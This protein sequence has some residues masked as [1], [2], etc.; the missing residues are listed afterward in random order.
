M[1]P[2]EFCREKGFSSTILLTYNF[3]PIFF[4]RVA[5]KE[6]WAGETGDILVVADRN[7]IAQS[8]PRWDGQLRELG[9]RY[10]LVAAR[11]PGTFHPKLILRVG[12]E[13]AAVWL[14]SGNVTS[15]GWGV[16]R[17]L[18][19]GWTVGPNRSDRGSWL[20][21]LLQRIAEW[22]PDTSQHNVIRRILE[23]PW[24]E[25]LEGITN[26]GGDRAILTS[27]GNLSLAS[28]VLARWSERRFDQVL[29]YTGSSDE[30]GAFLK[31]LHDNFGVSR[32]L[33]VASERNISFLRQQ[34]EAL[35]L[36][37]IVKRPVRCAPMHAK[38]Y[39]LTGRDGPAAIMGSPNCSAAAWLNS[40][41]GGG[42]VEAVA[43]YDR[44]Q[45]SE[46]EGILEMFQSN[47]L[48][49]IDLGNAGN[50]LK[51]ETLRAGPTVADVAWRDDLGTLIVTFNQTEHRIDHVSVDVRGEP[52]LLRPIDVTK[53]RWVAETPR[54]IIESGTCF[55][56]VTTRYDGNNQSVTTA[57]VNDVNELRHAS[58][59]RRIADALRGL[60]RTAGSSEQ[61][62]LIRMLGRIGR[63][64]VSE[65]ESF[66]DP[67]FAEPKADRK[68]EQGRTSKPINPEEF[69]RSLSEVDTSAQRTLDHHAG[70]NLS[71][72]GVMRALFSFETATFDEEADFIDETEG[73]E[74]KRGKK[75][76]ERKP[77]R[78]PV[79]IPDERV[80]ER[81]RKHIE[82]FIDHLSEKDFAEHCTASQLIQSAAYPIAVATLGMPTGWVDDLLARKWATRVFDILFRQNRTGIIQEVHTRYRNQGKDADFVR[83][84]GDGTLWLALLTAVSLPAW[85]GETG[86]F[87]K[88]LAIRS[89][90]LSR[91]L[92]AST[93]TGRMGALVASLEARRARAIMR[94]APRATS[95]LNNLEQMLQGDF[96]RLLDL[97]RGDRTANSVGDLLWKPEAGWAECQDTSGWGENIKAYLHLRADTKLISSRVFI[98]VTKAA[99]G[100]DR[101]EKIFARL[102]EQ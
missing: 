59:G 18:A 20:F 74:P 43:I 57:W 3:D 7:Q 47:D 12:Q 63:A 67:L 80:R 16:N 19:A 24:I 92:I 90:V 26:P 54:L 53:L 29:V 99:V 45:S 102:N 35:P 64:L 27:Y 81:L 11:T 89:V 33:V 15:G 85:E 2:R 5:L 55:L 79:N 73:D 84:V 37:T 66:P 4:E 17:E 88:A 60:G 98:N 71:L 86:G 14:G 1:N 48:I 69:I 13:G 40:P 97:Q 56:T 30:N 95:L 91:D 8:S 34:L 78:A 68:P 9:R 70:G 93:E 100:N 83:I 72:S 46:F 61:Q 22:G 96:Q 65:P 42:N 49:T 32:S 52:I 39:W 28:Q 75:G 62:E 10:Q 77:N 94:I 44:P 58:Q 23:T 6:L 76:K 87:E 41:A 38:F 21:P 51:R 25:S 36:S 31:W 101:L 50:L 82:E